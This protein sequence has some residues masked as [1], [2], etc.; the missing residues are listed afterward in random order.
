VL[1]T[2][3]MM[4]R[5]L[6][7]DCLAN[8]AGMS[9]TAIQASL[10]SIART[11]VITRAQDRCR[12]CGTIG[13]VVWGRSPRSMTQCPCSLPI[14]RF[15]VGHADSVLLVVLVHDEPVL[16]ALLRENRKT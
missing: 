11:I 6:C 3:L 5:P 15:H 7:V 1:V 10:V 14:L 16:R 13:P 12:A 4:E 2:G 8:K 9:L